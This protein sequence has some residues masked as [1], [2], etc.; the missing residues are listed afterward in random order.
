MLFVVTDAARRR[1]VSSVSGGH[2]PVGRRICEHF[3]C[4]LRLRA[5]FPAQK[6][7]SIWGEVFAFVSHICLHS[8]TL[9]VPAR[10]FSLSVLKWCCVRFAVIRRAGGGAGCHVDSPALFDFDEVDDDDD[11]HSFGMVVSFSLSYDA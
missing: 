6:I 3:R 8:V 7:P 9:L 1:N 11:D 5:N 4:Q 2:P 10:S